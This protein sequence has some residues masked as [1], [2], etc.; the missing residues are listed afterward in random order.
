MEIDQAVVDTAR[1]DFALRRV[2]GLRIEVGDAWLLM[3]DEDPPGVTTS[4]LGM[5]SG[6]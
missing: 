2:P 5:R 6:S 1:E 3:K 4:S